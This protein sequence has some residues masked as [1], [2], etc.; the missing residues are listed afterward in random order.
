MKNL[1][2]V[3]LSLFIVSSV[4]AKYPLCITNT[5][6]LCWL[7]KN[8]NKKEIITKN[9]ED[10]KQY[11]DKEEK[12][13]ITTYNFKPIHITNEQL[14]E[15][16]SLQNKEEYEWVY[17]DDDFSNIKENIGLSAYF[18]LRKKDSTLEQDL[19][20]ICVDKQ[21][22]TYLY[23]GEKFIVLTPKQTEILQ[24]KLKDKFEKLIKE[25]DNKNFNEVMSSIKMY[26]GFYLQ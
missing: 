10:N 24:S 25:S 20:V 19:I 4:E 22:N 5:D 8:N 23:G 6:P 9:Q 13:N 7:Y 26:L 17:L 18:S 12:K 16:I 2:V 11:N 14:N 21:N 1:I 3:I 15:F